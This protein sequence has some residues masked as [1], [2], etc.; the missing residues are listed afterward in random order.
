MEAD[1]AGGVCL[2]QIVKKLT[3]EESAENTDRKKKTLSAVD[4]PG[5]IGRN[6]TAWNYAVDMGMMIK[7]LPPGMQDSQEPD[8]S[9][10]MLRLSCNSV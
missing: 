9:S 8:F 5:A 6:A 10:K 3:S 4:P 7:R 1:Q 2:L